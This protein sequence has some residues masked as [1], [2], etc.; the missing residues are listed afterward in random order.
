[1][2]RRFIASV[3]AATLV[4][5]AGVAYAATQTAASSV[6]DVCVNDTNGLMRASATCRDGEHPATVGGGGSVQV[7]QNGTLSVAS[8]ETGG[9]KILPLTGVTV[10]GKCDTF[11]TPF[12][13]D[14]TTARPLVEAAAGTTMD[15]F[16][17]FGSPKV[18]SVL[19]PPVASFLPGM[20]SHAGTQ[21]AVL[22]AN[23][24]TATI[25]FGGYV[26]PDSKACSFLWQAVEAPN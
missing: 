10:S 23:G 5:G 24:A 4:L 12:G 19:L 9:A 6:T 7:T 21:Y 13:G 18:S 3:V 2:S 26:D 15:F 16:P 14:A 20:G 8:G 1:M 22:T 25:T 17:T 11:S